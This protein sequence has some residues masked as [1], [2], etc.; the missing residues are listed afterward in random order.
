MKALASVAVGLS[1]VGAPQVLAQQTAAP[2]N[3]QKP[4]IVLFL[5]DDMGWQD[6]SVPFWKEAT[7]LNR[8]FR[9]PNM[10]RLAVG[11]EVFTDAY[12]TPVCTPS[13]VSL[14]TGA[15]AARHRVTNWTGVRGQMTDD[16]NPTLQPAPWNVNGLSNTPETP[17]AFFA[18]TLPGLLH[19]AGYET[20]LVG[21]SHL[22]AAGT[23]GADPKNLG[24]DVNIG[25]SAAGH[26]ASYLGTSNYADG[27]THDVPNLE[28]YH[29]T[30]TFLTEALTLEANRAVNEAVAARKPFFLYLAH[31][32]VHEPI[33]KD[34]RF[35]QR[36]KDKE[37]GI[38][39]VEARYASLVE[40][41]DKS[42]G[43]VMDNLQKQGVADNTMV[44][45]LSDNGG[46]SV[47]QRAAPHNTQNL[48]LRAGKGSI[49]EGG[50]RVPMIVRWPGVTKAATRCEAPVIVD[51]FFST[52]LNIAGATAPASDGL[53][54]RP[55][56]RD[57]KAAAPDRALLW[58]FPNAWGEGGRDFAYYSA[59]RSGDW[60][61]I[62][63]YEPRRFELYNLRDDIGEQHDLAAENP[64][65]VQVLAGEMRRLLVERKAQMPLDKATGDSVPLPGA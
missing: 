51:D 22:G 52:L 14:M 15:N 53:D 33:Q 49:Y 29:G 38:P 43:D 5:V 42:L 17:R 13:R 11:G 21:K 12:A 26:P 36:Y 3:A 40:G 9:T 10:E 59:L 35:Y 27:G 50:V 4:N 7:P 30:K 55:W 20:I 41:M 6:T 45:F 47:G 32:A 39:D 16:E 58:H 57:A 56:L 63:R 48:P 28:K 31:Y 1:L 61:L 18:P 23:P 62:Y 46:L 2:Q 24:F 25:G 65:Q 60:K 44:V 54:L 64:Q 8:R 19:G 37:P 34:A